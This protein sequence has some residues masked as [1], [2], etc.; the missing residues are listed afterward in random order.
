MK[1]RF[2]NLNSY[3]QQIS[4][5]NDDIFFIFPTHPNSNYTIICSHNAW[6]LHGPTFT[7][8]Q[9]ALAS[10]LINVGGGGGGGGIFEF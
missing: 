4:T 8:I 7:D 10:D 5:R 3:T 6:F 9:S 2:A 1:E